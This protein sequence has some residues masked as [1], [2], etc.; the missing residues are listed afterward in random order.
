MSTFDR[1]KSVIVEVLGVDPDA[2]TESAGFIDDLGSD[3]LDVVEITM[4][5]EEEFDI[6]ITDDDWEPI[7]TIGDAVNF[8]S[9]R[10]E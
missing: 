1:V 6:E 5:L 2:V 9:K 10:V 3:S 4:G 8:V 7:I